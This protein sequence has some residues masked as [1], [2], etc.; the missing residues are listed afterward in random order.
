MSSMQAALRRARRYGIVLLVI[1]CMGASTVLIYGLWLLYSPLQEDFVEDRDHPGKPKV[2][3]PF[4][5]A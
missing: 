3:A 5:C 4:R 1:E 2:S